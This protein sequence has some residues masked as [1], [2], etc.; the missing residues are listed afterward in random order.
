M[1]ITEEQY[2]KLPDNLKQYFY[3]GNF[4]NTVKP[5]KLMS[6]LVTLLSRPKDVVLDPFIGSGTTALACKMLNRSYVGIELNKEYI[7]IAQKRLENVVIQDIGKS[8]IN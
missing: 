7:E 2:N 4:H 8:I 3:K 6:W 1:Q 5:V